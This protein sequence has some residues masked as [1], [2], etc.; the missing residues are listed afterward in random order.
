VCTAE[1]SWGCCSQ[2]VNQELASK[3]L[4]IALHCRTAAALWS[5]LPNGRCLGR[6]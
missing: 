3:A 6:A 4:G 2:P 5:L 1:G